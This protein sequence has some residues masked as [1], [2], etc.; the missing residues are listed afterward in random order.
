MVRSRIAVCS[1]DEDCSE[2]TGQ[3]MSASMEETQQLQ[4]LSIAN[5]ILNICK[6][7]S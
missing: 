2:D 7:L 5:A 3:L 4:L 1:L 6:P